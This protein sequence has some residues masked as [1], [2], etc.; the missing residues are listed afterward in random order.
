MKIRIDL[1]IVLFIILFYFTKQIEMYIMILIFAIIHELSHLMIGIFL[2]MKPDKIE[3]NLSGMSLSFK[4]QPDDYNKKVIKGNKLQIKNVIVAIAGPVMNLII[5]LIIDKIPMEIEQK[6]NVIYTNLLLLTF[7]LIPIYP[8]DGGRILKA[9]LHICL[10]KKKSEKI[11]N[12]ISFIVLITITFIS[13]IAIMKLKN[14]AIFFIII[15]LW[16][17][18]L[19]E[20]LIY[21]RRKKIYD[22]IE[23]NY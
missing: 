15:F 11:S 2:G 18:H 8:L 3:I 7:N 13:S 1:K 22:L 17:V 16:I 20:D 10:G 5:I 12:L 4:V 19:K 9:L 21:M 14:V 23:K 6:L